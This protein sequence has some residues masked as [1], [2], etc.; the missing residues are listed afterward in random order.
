MRAR[1]SH[2]AHTTTAPLRQVLLQRPC[3]TRQLE[4]NGVPL[5]LYGGIYSLISVLNVLSGRH[6]TLRRRGTTAGVKYKGCAQ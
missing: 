6:G 4:S 1:H 2:T 3:I 5:G